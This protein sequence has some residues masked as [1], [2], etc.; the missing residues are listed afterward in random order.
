MLM[1]G[2]Q[3][4]LGLG[5]HSERK[6]EWDG[7]NHQEAED[8]LKRCSDSDIVHEGVLSRRHYKSVRRRGEGRHE[9]KRGAEGDGKQHGQRTYAIGHGTL[10]CNRRHQHGSGRIGNEEGEQRCG[11]VNAG[12]QP[13]R[14]NPA[15]CIHKRYAHC[16]ADTCF[17]DRKSVV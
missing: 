12:H 7:E 17:L 11:E 5:S 1:H 4:I 16:L 8:Q 10:H 13:V 3:T 6:E 15:E 2:A 14:T 9:A